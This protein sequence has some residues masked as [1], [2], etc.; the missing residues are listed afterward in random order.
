[1]YNFS[2]IITTY[3]LDKYIAK[4]L[5]SVENQT[6]TNYN[7]IIIDDCSIDDT[8]NIVKSFIQNKPNY[9]LICNKHNRGVVYSRNL[10]F[11]MADKDYIAI[12]DGDDVW[13]DDKLYVQ[14]KYLTQNKVDIL[15]SDYLFIDKD[16]NHINNI[17]RTKENISYDD[18]LKQ[19]YIGCST[20]VF[21]RSLTKKYKM[22]A[23]F[24]H[25]DYVFWLTLLKH[26]ATAKGINKPLVNYRVLKDSRSNNKWLAAKN[27]FKIY[28]KYLNLSLVKSLIY[29]AHYA[30]SGFI[31]YF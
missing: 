7:V 19:N 1:M 9:T 31:K 26:G 24:G 23:D 4:T 28:R 2:I 12:L 22:I 15:C 6:Y 17:Y 14:N 30:V 5:N 13:T 16:G 3:N 25:E 21:T 8:V 11:S 29:F 27:R 20:A 18:L 10:G